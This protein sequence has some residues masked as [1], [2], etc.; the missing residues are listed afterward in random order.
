MKIRA[1]RAWVKRGF[2][3][4]LH[5][6]TFLEEWHLQGG[7]IFSCSPSLPVWL[8][9]HI[10]MFCFQTGLEAFRCSP[11]LPHGHEKE[12]KPCRLCMRQSLRL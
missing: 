12:Q 1:K 3:A 4:R 2:W 9:G 5:C 6:T 11:A 10:P 7:C 8:H